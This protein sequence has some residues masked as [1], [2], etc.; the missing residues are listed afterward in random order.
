MGCDRG[1]VEQHTGH[2][3]LFS[4][5]RLATTTSLSG[6]RHGLRRGGGGRTTHGATRICFFHQ[7]S[8]N[9]VSAWAVW[10]ARGGGKE[11]HTGHRN[12]FLLPNH[13]RP[14]KVVPAGAKSSQPPVPEDSGLL[15]KPLSYLV[16]HPILIL[17]AI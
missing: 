4:S 13:S 6:G 16:P 12:V 1:G 10:V 7:T 8:N 2:Q 3:V 15:S 5:S 17:C 14:V 9:L 11:Q